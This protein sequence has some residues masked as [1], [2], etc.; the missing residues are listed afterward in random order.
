MR[1]HISLVFFIL[2]SVVILLQLALSFVALL[3]E[4]SHN[5]L[6]HTATS[7]TKKIIVPETAKP[8]IDFKKMAEEMSHE[9]Y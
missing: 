2:A 9:K 8:K 4:Q 1:K 5:Q 6:L 7:Q 3:D